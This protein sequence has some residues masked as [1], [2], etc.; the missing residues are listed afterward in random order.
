MSALKKTTIAI[1]T[2]LT[3]A[4]VTAAPKQRGEAPKR[5]MSVATTDQTVTLRLDDGRSIDVPAHSVVVRDLRKE[6]AGST[7]RMR[8]HSNAE[9]QGTQPDAPAAME[10]G[11]RGMELSEFR[12]LAASTQGLVPAVAKIRYAQDG[13]V[14]RARIMVFDNDDAT[15]K[16]LARVKT[17]RHARQLEQ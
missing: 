5:I 4:V 16:F 8:V 14:R 9:N 11:G 1:A 2:L 10:Q 15:A 12:A 3:A 13:S 7:A 17:T 6:K